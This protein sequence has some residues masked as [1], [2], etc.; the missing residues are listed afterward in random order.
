MSQCSRGD[1]LGSMCVGE[2]FQLG[3]LWGFLKLLE[4]NQIYS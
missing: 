3:K 2:H 4:F 1:V